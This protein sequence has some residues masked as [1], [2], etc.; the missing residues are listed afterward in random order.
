M[1]LHEFM[2]TKQLAGEN[3]GN[4]PV[5]EIALSAEGIFGEVTDTCFS[6][7]DNYFTEE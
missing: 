3:N 7:F 5:S 2:L 4:I 6:P 1:N